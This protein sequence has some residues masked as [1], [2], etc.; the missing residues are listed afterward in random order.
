MEETAK[1]H[2]TDHPSV[3][4]KAGPFT[5]NINVFEETLFKKKIQPIRDCDQILR[6]AAQL[7]GDKQSSPLNKVHLQ[8]TLKNKTLI[9]PFM[10]LLMVRWEQNKKLRKRYGPVA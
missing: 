6:L 2:G 10:V 3:E 7:L 9:L 8:A 5:E 4:F 1:R